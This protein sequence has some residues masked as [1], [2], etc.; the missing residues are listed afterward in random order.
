M[1]SENNL[2]AGVS[3]PSQTGRAG[4]ESAYFNPS[5]ETMSREQIEALQLERLQKT[6]RH[7]MN[8]EFYRKKFEEAGITPDD[9]KT[10]ADV[11]KI[12]Q[13][14]SDNDQFTTDPSTL[15]SGNLIQAGAGKGSGYNGSCAM[16]AIDRQLFYEIR[17][18]SDGVLRSRQLELGEDRDCTAGFG[19]IYD[20]A[21]H[22]S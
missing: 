22:I 5:Y 6:V 4:G 13:E 1:N 21:A 14:T 8:N 10:L 12:L 9:I 15:Y 7:C 19:M 3:A 16:E 2:S 20:F 17:I 11:R 18:F